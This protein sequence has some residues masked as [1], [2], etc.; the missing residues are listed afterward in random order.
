MPLWVSARSANPESLIAIGS[1][2]AVP[3]PSGAFSDV[4]LH[5]G[6]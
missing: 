4:Q 6:E 1:M 5:I 3:A 2:D